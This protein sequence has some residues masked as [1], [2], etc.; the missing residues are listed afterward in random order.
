MEELKTLGIEI[1]RDIV[2]PLFDLL[3]IGIVISGSTLM[4]RLFPVLGKTKLGKFR[5]VFVFATIISIGYT[6]LHVNLADP[7]YMLGKNLFNYFVAIL[8]YHAV[9]KT[10][11]K[12]WGLFQKKYLVTSHRNSG[13]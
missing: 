9:I 6:T 5:A 10:I 11:V 8:I 3:Y 13:D 1:L 7:G 12:L 2:L 4:F